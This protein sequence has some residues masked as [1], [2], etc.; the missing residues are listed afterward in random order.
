MWL[1]AYK[2]VRPILP[3]S[4]GIATWIIAQFCGAAFEQSIAAAISMA[5][6]TIGASF[7]H[8]GG[9]NWM[10]ARKS[11]R[12]K[13]KNPETIRLLGLVI[14]SFSIAI[15]VLWLPKICVLICL[16]NTI[17]IAAYSAK[18]SS[19]WTTKN[20]TMAIVCITPIVIG[21]QAG[22]T[23]HP[24]VGWGIVM[25][26]FAYFAREVIKDVKDILANEGKR[27]TLPMVLGINHALQLA[28]IL[29]FISAIPII[30]LLQFT[31][32]PFQITMAAAAILLLIFTGSMLLVKKKAWRCETLIQGS[33]CLLLL[34]LW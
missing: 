5:L 30:K 34:A 16:F 6:N 11:E 20:I 21:W 4:S 26:A 7:Y 19:H 9:A 1:L 29:L 14:F 25:A 22:V 24:I 10:Y 2:L 32:G 28:G 3:I 15:A 27:V 17:A 31:K 18:L 13:F 8:Y 23:S 12:F 33:I